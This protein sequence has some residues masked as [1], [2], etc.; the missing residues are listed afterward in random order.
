[1]HTGGQE[2]WGHLR[3]LPRRQVRSIEHGIGIACD[4]SVFLLEATGTWVRSMANSKA[5]V[6]CCLLSMPC[7]LFLPGGQG[8]PHFA[9]VTTVLCAALPSS[10]FVRISVSS[11][12]VL[13]DQPVQLSL[14]AWD[15][16]GNP[17]SAGLLSDES[18]DWLCLNQPNPNQTLKLE[19]QRNELSRLSCT[20]WGSLLACFRT[21]FG[22]SK[23]CFHISLSGPRY[24]I[25]SPFREHM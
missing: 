2:S 3:I 4:T 7:S 9:L 12:R 20:A 21:R 18:V 15:P 6:L 14:G 25:C 19:V 5:D 22:V 13:G 1:M 23:A 16:T 8:D 11:G 17:E 24:Y 10:V